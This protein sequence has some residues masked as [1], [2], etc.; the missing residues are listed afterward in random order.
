MALNDVNH[1][2]LGTAP[3]PDRR[4]ALAREVLALLRRA[5]P[6]GRRL[7][8]VL[9]SDA[10]PERSE[11]P[12]VVVRGPDALARLLYPPSAASM[13]MSPRRYASPSLLVDADS[14]HADESAT[15]TARPFFRAGMALAAAAS[16]KTLVG[17]SSASLVPRARLQHGSDGRPTVGSPD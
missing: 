15:W 5:L 11:A 10:P 13:S 7:E 9:A 14:A 3:G 12:R 8:F 4:L 16:I 1:V 17:R 6:P 2:G